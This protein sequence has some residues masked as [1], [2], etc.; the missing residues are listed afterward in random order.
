M[1]VH[2]AT[3]GKWC[4]QMTRPLEVPPRQNN[5]GRERGRDETGSTRPCSLLSLP[6]LFGVTL[7]GLAVGA[8]WDIDLTAVPD[9]EGRLLMHLDDVSMRWNSRMFE[10]WCW[11]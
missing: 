11:E 7:S 1:Y 6:A 8:D 3:G 9:G 2:S 10:S 5:A 4:F